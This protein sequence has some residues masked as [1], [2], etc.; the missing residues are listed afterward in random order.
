MK[1]YLFFRYLMIALSIVTILTIPYGLFESYKEF[2]KKRN[3]K[4]LKTSIFFSMICLIIA[5]IV[6]FNVDYIIGISL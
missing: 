2:K 1:L 6:L 5:L 3:Y 4:E